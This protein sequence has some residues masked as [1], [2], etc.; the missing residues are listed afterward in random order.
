[1]PGRLWALYLLQSG[2]A[3][4]CCGLSRVGASLG[5]SMALVAGMALGGT[6]AAGA[7]FGIVPFVS[8]RGLV[9]LVGQP[10]GWL[11]AS[12]CVSAPRHTTW[13]TVAGSC[14]VV[15]APTVVATVALPVA[16]AACCRAL[17]TALWALAAALVRAPNGSLPPRSCHQRSLQSS[18]PPGRSPAPLRQSRAAHGPASSRAVSVPR[19]LHSAAGALLH[20]QQRRLEPRLPG[21]GGPAAAAPLALQLPLP[22]GRKR[23]PL[24]LPCPTVRC[25]VSLCWGCQRRSSARRMWVAR[26]CADPAAPASPCKFN[27]PGQGLTALAATSLLL[28]LRFPMWWAVPARR[29]GLQH[30]LTLAC[31]RFHAQQQAGPLAVGLRVELAGPASALGSPRRLQGWHAARCLAAL[32]SE[33]R[34]LRRRGPGCG[35]GALRRGLLLEGLQQR[36]APAG[37][38]HLRTQVCERFCRSCRHAALASRQAGWRPGT[39]GWKARPPAVPAIKCRLPFLSTFLCLPFPLCNPAGC[40]VAVAARR[41]CTAGCG[42]G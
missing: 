10:L 38:A 20:R 34:L 39:E 30:Q 4:C 27:P 29:P 42:G 18:P 25:P 12:N 5:G 40:R 3:A 2:A 23:D 37:H 22:A 15:K 8:R 7:T 36:G 35:G 24:A 11:P 16:S 21:N 13:C 32:P 26:P 33:R 17:S 31:V 9:R 28:L 1:M 14:I 6:A 19:R 41:R